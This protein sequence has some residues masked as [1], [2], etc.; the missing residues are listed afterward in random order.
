[1]FDFTVQKNI[2][3]CAYKYGLRF[4]QQRPPKLS[5]KNDI[6]GTTTDTMAKNAAT[7][8]PNVLTFLKDIFKTWIRAPWMILWSWN[9][10]V[11]IVCFRYEYCS[12][13]SYWVYG[14]FQKLN[15]NEA[16]L[17]PLYTIIPNPIKLFILLINN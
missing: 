12:C 15:N 14:P 2:N 9:D 4:L 13:C 10:G 5:D 11:L 7:R 6:N 8:R 1:M 16:I 3:V 17:V